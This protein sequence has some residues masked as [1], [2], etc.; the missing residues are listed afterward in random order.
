MSTRLRFLSGLILATA[1]MSAPGTARA[2]AD[3]PSQQR[4]VNPTLVPAWAM[5]Q[6]QPAAPSRAILT[7]NT[8][9]DRRTPNTLPDG[10]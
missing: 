8:R 4:D 1:L 6:E 3:P 7:P 5:L 10:H 2:G 9:D